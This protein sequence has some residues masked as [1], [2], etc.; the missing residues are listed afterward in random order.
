MCSTLHLLPFNTLN[1][2]GCSSTYKPPSI[3]YTQ[4]A[5]LIMQ[6]LRTK[7][8]TKELTR[9]S[10]FPERNL[11]PGNVRLFLSVQVQ[12]LLQRNDSCAHPHVGS[13]TLHD[14]PFQ[15]ANCEVRHHQRRAA[16]GWAYMLRARYCPQHPTIPTQDLIRHNNW[17][18][19]RLRPT[20]SDPYMMYSTNLAI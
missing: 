1:C 20:E 14:R 13:A 2:I 18:T 9:S 11:R 6:A 8:L 4:E 5:L 16:S 19:V 7:E 3:C 12:L 10:T 15:K 17:T